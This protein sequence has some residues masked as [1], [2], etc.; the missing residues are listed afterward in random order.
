MA[1]N[2]FTINQISKQFGIE[3]REQANLFPAVAPVITPEKS[4]DAAMRNGRAG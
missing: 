2:Q 1:Y 4:G 3:V